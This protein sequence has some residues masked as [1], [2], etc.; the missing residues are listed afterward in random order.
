MRKIKKFNKL[1]NNI[2]D[3]E[4][5]NLEIITESNKYYEEIDELKK[6]NDTNNKK[7]QE[8]EEKLEENE[9]YFDDNEKNRTENQEKIKE[10]NRLNDK[11]NNEKQNIEK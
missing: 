11:L 4:N 6:I 8:L 3:L 5:K 2:K 7:I 9:E 10:L 1:K